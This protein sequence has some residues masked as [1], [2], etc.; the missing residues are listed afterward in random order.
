[1][2]IDQAT[3]PRSRG[4]WVAFGR[5]LGFTDEQLRATVHGATDDPAWSERD[6]LLV[7]LVDELHD[8][9]TVSADLW[10]KL[11]AEWEP[12]THPELIE[13][14]ERLSEDLVGEAHRR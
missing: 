12:H 8:T 3:A 11:A 1:M 5:P 13:F 10:D 9:G 2:P 6:A 4:S 7:R 14:I